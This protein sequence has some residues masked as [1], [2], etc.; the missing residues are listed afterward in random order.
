[1]GLWARVTLT[2]LLMSLTEG[3]YLFFLDW[4]RPMEDAVRRIATEV[5]LRASLS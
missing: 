3:V 4:S 2:L 1:M 5:V